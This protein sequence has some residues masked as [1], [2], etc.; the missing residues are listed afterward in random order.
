MIALPT[1]MDYSVWGGEKIRHKNAEFCNCTKASN[2]L[3]AHGAAECCSAE[4]F[5]R[6][7]SAEKKKQTARVSGTEKHGMRVYRLKLKVFRMILF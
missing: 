1:V 2:W 4:F 6:W 3:R 7:I 5:A